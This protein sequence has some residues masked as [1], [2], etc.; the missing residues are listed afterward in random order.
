M[1]AGQEDHTGRLLRIVVI[2]DHQ[3][4]AE[5]LAEALDR[6]P[7]LS[8]VGMADNMETGVRMCCALSPD[9]VVLDYRLPGGDGLRAAELILGNDPSTR[10]LMLTGDPTAEAIHRA[11]AVG[12]CGFLPKDGALGILLDVLRTLRAGEFVVAPA[13]VSRLRLLG[14]S[15]DVPGPSLTAREMEVL[16]LMASGHDVA[17]NS[18]ALAISA[19]TCRGYVKSILRKLDAHSQLEAVAVATKM[20]MLGVE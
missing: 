14:R 8:C 1:G 17:S 18:R 5:L 3:T 6:E 4:F 20:G 10:I 11:A 7:D 16:R 13:L 15:I 19:H 12:I 2:D 9:L